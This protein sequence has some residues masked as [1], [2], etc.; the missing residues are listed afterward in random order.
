MNTWKLAHLRSTR[1]PTVSNAPEGESS[2]MES[3]PDSK[4]AMSKYSKRQVLSKV[5]T[6]SYLKKLCKGDWSAINKTSFGS[7]D[8][9]LFLVFLQKWTPTW[10][11]G[12]LIW[13]TPVTTL[14]WLIY[15]DVLKM[16]LGETTV[17][18]HTDHT[19]SKNLGFLRTRN[20]STNT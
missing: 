5:T 11:Y 20:N 3:M 8:V 13:H 9:Y 10:P 4:G 7:K 19:Y 1:P 16:Q 18:V 2:S 14:S 15:T 6:K 12:Y 17:I